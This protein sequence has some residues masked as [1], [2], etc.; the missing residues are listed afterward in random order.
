MCRLTA[1]SGLTAN[2]YFLSPNS[3]D[4]LGSWASADWVV[5]LSDWSEKSRVSSCAW[6]VLGL[7]GKQA[8]TVFAVCRA[9]FF[10]LHNDFLLYVSFHLWVIVQCM[11]NYT[12]TYACTV[13]TCS[14]RSLF[15]FTIKFHVV[16][17]RQINVWRVLQSSRRNSLQRYSTSCPSLAEKL[18]TATKLVAIDDPGTC[19]VTAAIASSACICCN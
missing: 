18:L 8:L 15:V 2:D 9:F 17:R 5:I 1:A 13:G 10:Y 4:V 16:F 7:Q 11:H 19:D 14:Y 3:G 12:S 6:A